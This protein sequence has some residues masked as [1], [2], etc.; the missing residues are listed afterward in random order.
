MNSLDLDRAAETFA[1]ATDLTVGLEEEFSILDPR[2]ARTRA[3]LRGAAR[4]CARAPTRC[5][6][7]GIAGELIS[8]EIEIISGVGADLHDALAPPARA[9]PARCSRSPRA[10][11]VGARRDRH[12]SVGRLPRAA[13]HRHRAL[14]PRRGGPEVRRLAQQHL[15]PARPRRRARHRPRGAGLRPAAPGAAAAA[16]DLR[17]LAV[18]RRARQRP[19]LGAHAELH[20]ELPALRRARR[21]RRLARPTASTSS[22]CCAPTR[23]SSSRRSGGRCGRTSA[24]ARSR[25]ASATRR[26]PRRSPT[27]SPALMV[28]CVAQAARDVD[29]G[30]PFE[31]SA[32]RG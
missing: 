20:Q 26:P 14:P 16:G 5:C 2:H 8:S 22:S 25:C 31:R 10:S 11:G 12:P 24:S 27:R 29:E 9:P 13:D 6:A 4:R 21:V 17:Q 19:A 15:Q 1:D 32:G 18:P 28:A 23:S 3:A 7:S 30:V